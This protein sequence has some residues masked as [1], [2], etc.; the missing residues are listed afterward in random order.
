V[1]EEMAMLQRF[2]WTF[3]LGTAALLATLLLSLPGVEAVRADD[4]VADVS[5][6]IESA[7]PSCEGEPVAYKPHNRV[8]LPLSAAARQDPSS[9]P[10]ALNTRG[11]N[12]GP[13][14]MRPPIQPDN[15]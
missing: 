3:G 12:Y 8:T 11:Y 2:D 9:V 13:A 6:A 5:A 1:I 15:R 10:V 14:A 7:G 4:S